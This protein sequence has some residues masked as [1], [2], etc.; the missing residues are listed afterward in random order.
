[1]N[2]LE[3]I[4]MIKAAI[5]NMSREE[6]LAFVGEVKP[7]SAERFAMLERW[8]LDSPSDS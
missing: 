2:M 8:I 7:E 3:Q 1:M 4:R 6:L 5:E